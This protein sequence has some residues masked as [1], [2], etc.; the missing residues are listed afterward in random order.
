[1][2]HLL[3]LWKCPENASL[4]IVISVLEIERSL[5]EPNLASRMDGEALLLV[6]LREN[7]QQHRQCEP[8]YCH[9]GETIPLNFEICGP[10]RIKV[11]PGRQWPK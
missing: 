4:S 10:P 3:V 2:S 6:F 11:L 5:L 8:A 9:A 1:V 7:A